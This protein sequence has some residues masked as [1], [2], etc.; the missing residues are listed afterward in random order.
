MARLPDVTS[1][2]ARPVPQPARALPNNASVGRG[3]QRAANAQ[4]SAAG[5]AGRGAATLSEMGIRLAAAQEKIQSRED[6][7]ERARAYRQFDEETQAELLRLQ[8]EGDLSSVETMRTYKD[9]VETRK[10][11]LF[12]A[13]KGSADSRTALM[14]RLEGRAASV[15]DRATVASLEGQRAL[16]TQTLGNDLNRL[17]ATAQQSP[18]SLPQLFQELDGQINDMAG[19]LTPEEEHKFRIGGRSTLVE[20]AVGSLISR[21]SFDRAET[22]LDLPGVD[23]ILDPT[24]HNRLRDRI[25]AARMEM[26]KPEDLVEVGDPTSPTGSRFVPKSMAAGLPGKPRKPLVSITHK[27]EEEFAKQLG[28]MDA[29][30][31]TGIETTA[32]NAYNTLGEVARMNAAIES[33]RFTTGVFADA[34]HFIG[35]VADFLEIDTE[36]FGKLVGDAATAD[37]LDAAAAR[38]GVEAAQKLGRITNM[39]LQFIIDSLPSL[40]RTPEGNKI[41]LETMERVANREIQVATLADQYVTEYNSL[42]PPGTKSYFQA[43]RDLEESD[44]VI[45]AQLRQR[46]ID[47]SRAAP[48]S[49]RDVLGNL[50]GQEEPPEGFEAPP[51]AEFV[52]MQDGKPVVRGSDGKLYIQE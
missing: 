37:T 27:G 30:T 36:D 38:L 8:T 2:G 46:I 20:T 48:K 34:R 31:L 22:L 29:E 4:L 10:N 45:S 26:L 15:L 14:E 12:E 50:T 13:H 52:R 6:S 3:V 51:G 16:V 35:R 40:T 49:F 5:E 24:S 25:T 17:S 7:V 1:F 42:R 9:F 19:A 18:G 28:K 11:E 21:G 43:V 44:P 33:G 47:G 32:Q 39:S 41:L 23:S